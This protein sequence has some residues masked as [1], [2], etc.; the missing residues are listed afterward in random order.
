[1]V[2]NRD[3]FLFNPNFF[4]LQRMVSIAFACDIVTD[5]VPRIVVA[6][7]LRKLQRIANNY[8]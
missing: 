3:R 8:W 5:Y 7:I 4:L 2:N 6:R 1:M